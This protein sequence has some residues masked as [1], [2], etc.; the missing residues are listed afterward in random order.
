MSNYQS[1]VGTE[2]APFFISPAFNNGVRVL[3]GISDGILK[4]MSC[5]IK[6]VFLAGILKTEQLST[7]SSQ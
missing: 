3:V 1:T 5:L 7:A 6:A 2:I 4:R